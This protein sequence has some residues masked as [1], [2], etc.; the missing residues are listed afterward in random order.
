MKLTE[1]LNQPHEENEILDIFLQITRLLRDSG[2]GQGRVSPALYEV[3][4]ANNVIYLETANADDFIYFKAP[5]GNGKL[6][7]KSDVFSLGMLLYFLL[8]NET[9]YQ[10][11]GI[12][13]NSITKP[14]RRNADIT[15]IKASDNRP[16][17]LLMERMTAGEPEK[18][19]FIKDVLSVLSNNVCRFSV[20]LKNERTGEIFSE[21][22]RSFTGSMS[23]KFT[24]EPEYFINKV[25][26]KPSTPKPLLIP[27]R[28]VRKNYELD[29]V[30][31]KEGRW[32]F[33]TRKPDA[34][35]VP[36]ANQ[37]MLDEVNRATA[38]L[39]YINAVY[40]GTGNAL[41]CETDGFSF[42]LSYAA[43][44]IENYIEFNM[45]GRLSAPERIDARILSLLKQAN[46]SLSDIKRVAI[47]GNLPP[48]MIK[49]INDLFPEDVYIY[50]LSQEEIL[51]GA[52]IF[53]AETVDFNTDFEPEKENV[54]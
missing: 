42:E 13:I 52:V 39:Y 37:E 18:R 47:Y 24:P 15:V 2:K 38:A 30:Y 29:M 50:E 21:V 26:L 45:T 34:P 35:S 46:G 23:Y 6:I 16:I 10:S 44:A 3:D 12:A 43:S 17:S 1:W 33:A 20:F 11:K 27:F 31:G 36:P 9:Y 48:Q 32:S 40:T 4:Q 41:L 19:P 25:T 5:E 14:R 51:K 49:A 7:E 8:N 22:S 53:K 54:Q 28:L